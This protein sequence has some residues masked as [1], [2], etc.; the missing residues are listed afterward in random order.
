MASASPLTTS[1]SSLRHLRPLTTPELLDRAF[2]ILARRLPIFILCSLLTCAWPFLNCWLVLYPER[3]SPGLQT[4]ALLTLFLIG[5]LATAIALASA[6][7]TWLYP[8][9]LLDNEPLAKAAFNRLLP[10]VVTRLVISI[11][12]VTLFLSVPGWFL[13][14]EGAVGAA[15][16]GY[17]AGAAASVVFGLALL[18]HWSLSP[19]I[20]LVERK[21]VFTGLNRSFELMRSGATGPLEVPPPIRRLLA[22]VPLIVLVAVTTVA[23]SFGATYW[24]GDGAILEAVRQWEWTPTLK[25]TSLLGEATTWLFV[26]PVLWPFIAVLYV[27]CRMR[28]EGM[29]FQMRLLE[30]GGWNGTALDQDDL[31]GA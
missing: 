10:F 11:V 28:R 13:S 7:Q 24:R 6:F 2:A 20:V 21:G 8:Q 15:R 1:G 29:D 19:M 25:F 27:D 14:R 9:R 16:I 31:T 22:I 12:A 26:Y 17:A 18:L 30:N 3:L 5:E 23:I 4:G